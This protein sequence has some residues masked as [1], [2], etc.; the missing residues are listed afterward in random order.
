MAELSREQLIELVTREVCR[1]L[2]ESGSPPPDPSGLPKA[3]V[4]GGAEPLPSRIRKKYQ[5]LGMESYSC[6]ESVAQYDAVFLTSLSLTELA[7]IALGRDTRPVQC[8]VINALMEGKPVYLAEFALAW[9]KKK[10]RMPSGFYQ[11][12]EGYVRTL[13]RFGVLSLEGPNAVDK[14]GSRR[15]PG[16]DL[17]EGVITEAL[18]HTLAEGSSE[19]ILLVRRGTVITPSARDVFLHAGK[20]IQIV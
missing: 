2:G 8:A 12:L 3:L 14:D 18:A 13:Q 9:R 6:P 7:D 11:M 20:E 17:P 19:P 4:V 10:S 15:A 5:F 1:V 16:A